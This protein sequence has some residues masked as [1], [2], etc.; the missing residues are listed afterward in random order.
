MRSSAI[1]IFS[2]FFGTFGAPRGK[3]RS[4]ERYMVDTP[5]L[6]WGG[7]FLPFYRGFLHLRTFERA[8]R[9]QGEAGTPG[10][11]AF[12]C[13]RNNSPPPAQGSEAAGGG[14]A[15]YGIIGFDY[16]YYDNYDY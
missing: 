3:I 6:P 2:M 10:F 5:S 9:V 11:R 8:P 16:Y 13:I 7:P 1:S 12:C 4:A 14:D 15:G